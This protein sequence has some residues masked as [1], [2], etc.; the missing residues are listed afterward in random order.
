MAAAARKPL[1]NQTTS[2]AWQAAHLI[3]SGAVP[4]VDYVPPTGHGRKPT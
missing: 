4:V 1:P 3:T 2:A